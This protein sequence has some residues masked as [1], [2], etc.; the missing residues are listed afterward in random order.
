MGEPQR[1]ERAGWQPPRL[2]IPGSDRGFNVRLKARSWGTGRQTHAIILHLSRLASARRI[3]S[4][5]VLSAPM[6]AFAP[7]KFA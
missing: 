3:V 2:S 6:T 4:I 7:G 5:N 1:G